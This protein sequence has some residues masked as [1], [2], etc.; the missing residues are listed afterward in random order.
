MRLAHTA[1]AAI[2]AVGLAACGST[3]VTPP[4]PRSTLA[5][6]VAPTAAPTPTAR[7]IATTPPPTPGVSVTVTCSNVP[8]MWAHPYPAGSILGI[9]TWH[10][11]TLGDY[12]GVGLLT[13]LVTSHT[14]S[15]GVGG[16]GHAINAFQQGTWEWSELTGLDQTVTVAHGHLTIPA[17]PGNAI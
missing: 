2:V 3:A 6:T 17:C 8:E 1:G 7:P 13:T 15:V 11:L 14:M 4:A 10:N 9:A 16:F 5:R 12:F